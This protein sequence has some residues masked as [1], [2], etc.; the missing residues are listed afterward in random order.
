MENKER[1]GR[2]KEKD[3]REIKG[4]KRGN[5]HLFILQKFLLCLMYQAPEIL[6]RE[7]DKS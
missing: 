1:K 5:Y 7:S 3:A 2:I 4:K 6:S